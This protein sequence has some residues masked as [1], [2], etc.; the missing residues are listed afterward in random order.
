MNGLRNFLK[1]CRG[2]NAKVANCW[3]YPL[4]LIHVISGQCNIFGEPM[5]K[6][7]NIENVNADK[8]GLDCCGELFFS[9]EFLE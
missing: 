9:N 3:C 6:K 4:L 8:C 1:R 2:Y 5:E 7:I